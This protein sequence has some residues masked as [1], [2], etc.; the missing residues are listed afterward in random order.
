MMFMFAQNALNLVN[1][2]RIHVVMSSKDMNRISI[3]NNRISQIFGADNIF[4]VESDEDN[5]QIFLKA[6]HQVECPVT[7]T[8]VAENGFTQDIE[9]TLQDTHSK[10]I[11]LKTPE[12]MIEETCDGRENIL[13]MI[14]HY[15]CQDMTRYGPIKKGCDF[16]YKAC[17]VRFKEGYE[18]LQFSLEVYEMHNMQK[19]FVTIEEKSLDA[20]QAV[21][22]ENTCLMPGC[23][24][25]IILVKK[26]R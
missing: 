8:I 23:K 10:T 21:Y 24:A 17:P 18:S 11:L 19:V 13:T 7:I 6:L 14:K 3:V 20:S 1:H 15:F 16:T 2:Q 5:G 9:I 4:S 26:K 25:K 22:V 12:E